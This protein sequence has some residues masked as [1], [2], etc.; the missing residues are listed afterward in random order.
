[1]KKPYSPPG[2]VTVLNGGNFLV[3]WA[4]IVLVQGAAELMQDYQ[5]LLRENLL[6]VERQ[7]EYQLMTEKGGIQNGETTE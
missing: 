7:Y 4:K 2:I 1:M 6:L 5:I 3:Y